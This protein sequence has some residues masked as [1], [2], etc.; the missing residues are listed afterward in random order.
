MRC[1]I[2]DRLG[3]AAVTCWRHATLRSDVEV[4]FP[5]SIQALI[6]ARLDTLQQERKQ[7]L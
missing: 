6:A 4:P 7:L 1:C 3:S 5:E 2:Q